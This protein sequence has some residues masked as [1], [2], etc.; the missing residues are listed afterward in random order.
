MLRNYLLIAFRSLRKNK[1]HAVVN[2]AGLAL[3]N[4]LFDCNFSYHPF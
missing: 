1:G 2:V 3:G 4:H